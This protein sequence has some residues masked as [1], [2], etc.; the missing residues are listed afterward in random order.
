MNKRQI[1]AARETAVELDKVVRELE[2][3]VNGKQ[4]FL[5]DLKKQ[6]TDM[7]ICR[8][9]EDIFMAK[10]PSKRILDI[11]RQIDT[12]DEVCDEEPDSPEERRYNKENYN[13]SNAV[14]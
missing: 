3:L 9:S 14:Y 11:M 13:K 4:G 8:L 5:K 7:G 2:N 1:I 6:T 10:T 12:I